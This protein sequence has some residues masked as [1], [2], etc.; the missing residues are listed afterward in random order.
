MFLSHPPIATTPSKP[1]APTTVST[2]SAR[3]Q[4]IA[5]P[6]RAHAN[7]VGHRDRIERDRLR[8]RLL[9]AGRRHAREFIDVHVAGR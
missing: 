6:G 3:N 8:A 5:H 4:G 1:C 9:D 2:E 7:A